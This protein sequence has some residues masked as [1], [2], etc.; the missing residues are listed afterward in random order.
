[1]NYFPFIKSEMRGTFEWISRQRKRF[2]M[3]ILCMKAKPNLG[4]RN[5]GE[6]RP[7]EISRALGKTS[8]N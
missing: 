6:N 4:H 8:E 5:Y 7:W 1:M 3:G 2:S